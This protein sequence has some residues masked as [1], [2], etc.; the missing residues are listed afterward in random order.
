M[1]E[2]IISQQEILYPEI[3]IK[4]LNQTVNT[5]W[6]LAQQQTSGIEIIDEKAKQVG[7]Y[8]RDLNEMIRDSLSQLTPILRQFTVES[9]FSTIREIDEA[10]LDPDLGDGDRKALLKEREQS[11]LKL[12]KNAEY[13]I[14]KFSKRTSQLAEKIGDI[15]NIVIAERLKDILTRTEAQAAK[16]QSD[17]E[18]K[19][20][21]RKK[22]DAERDKIIESQDVIRAN[23][24]A[25]MFK[26]FIP[27]ASDIDSLDFTDPKKEAIK[28]AIKQSA[29]I[30]RKVLG[31]ISE[32][33]K[34]IDLADARMKL[35]DQIDQIMEESKE[36]KTTLWKTE[37]Q[38]SGL[39]D[40]MQID[41]ER[42]TMLSEADKLE[43]AWRSFTNQLHKLSDKEVNQANITALIKG[44]LDFLDNLASQYNKLK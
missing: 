22:L 43:Q 23:N 34:Y 26:D 20:E 8:S 5:I 3:N 12:S 32:G 6:C 15:S 10:L 19:A 42:T 2:N 28:Q 27:S 38:L 33:L 36:L 7:L 25:D 31:K 13:V 16:L 40:M 24:I 39:K 29:E 4:A 37:Q 11:S 9:I 1:S 14:D 41:T 18:K 30:I 35:S 21:K 17:I 44:Q